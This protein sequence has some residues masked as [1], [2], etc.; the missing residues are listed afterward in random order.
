M[1]SANTLC[2]KLLNV[3]HCVVEGQDFYTGSDGV[4]HLRIKSR[5]DKWNQNV[6]P[7]CHKRRKSFDQH[8]AE[9]RTWRGLDLGLLL[10]K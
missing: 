6:C 5:P 8:G 4:N 1:A 9:P 3:K 7:F 10:L 2:K